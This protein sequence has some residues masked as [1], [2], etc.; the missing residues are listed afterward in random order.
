M[1]KK[2]VYTLSEWVT[3]WLETYKRPLIRPSTYDSYRQYSTHIQCDT[4]LRELSGIDIQGLVSA[5]A[6]EQKAHSTICH[7][8]TLCRQSLRTARKLG[9]ID[10]MDCMDGIELPRN[11]ARTVESLSAD[12]CARVLSGMSGSHYG[13]FFA[14]LL[15]TGCRVG[16]LI[17]LR[18]RDVDFFAGCI[19]IEHTD[20]QGSLQPVKTES[21]R[22]RL[23]LTD[24]L[25][26][27]LQGRARM[28]R[29]ERVFLTTAGTS[30]RY[31]SVLDSWHWYCRRVG[32]R[33]CGLHVLRHSFAHRALRAG[34]PVRVVS[35]WLGHADVSIT[36]S[37]YD[38][39]TRDDMTAAA[40]TL[41][42]MYT[43]I[44]RA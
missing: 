39:V 42:E 5:M 37:I 28:G 41:T 1:E 10:S 24:Q 30:I 2:D 32:I 16:E 4:P 19:Y 18:W 31:R 11:C 8:L 27:I 34:I 43:Q 6:R 33:S 44:K 12:E 25:R 20:Y 35:A 23:P 26:R 38:T 29:G 13:P 3:L 14:A 17:A 7:M 22:R 9:L 15:L 21:G 36:L 40:A